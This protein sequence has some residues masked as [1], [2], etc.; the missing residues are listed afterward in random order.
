MSNRNPR[1]GADAAGTSPSGGTAW[2]LNA[3]CK[4]AG[5]SLFFGEWD[6]SPDGRG[7]RETEARAMC[8]G[9]PSRQP[10]LEF[11]VALAIPWGVW[12]GLSEDERRG[13]KGLRRLPDV[14][15]NGLHRMTPENAKYVAGTTYVRCR[16]C[17][18]ASDRRTRASRETR[19]TRTLRRQ[20]EEEAA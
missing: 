7:A 16:E 11:A 17:L 20:G 10:C 1:P 15:G 9:C 3:A 4:D 18:R 8:A 14:C 13:M 12:G 19:K 2:R 5:Q 6:E